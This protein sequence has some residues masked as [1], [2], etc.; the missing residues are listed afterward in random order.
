LYA[1]TA[2]HSFAAPQIMCTATKSIPTRLV[3]I[4]CLIMLT[5]SRQPFFI[6]IACSSSKLISMSC[7][8]STAASASPCQNSSMFHMVRK[9][10]TF[11]SRC[12]GVTRM[13]RR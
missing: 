3:V 6:R 1:V 11:G 12:D 8:A 2:D 7:M 5:A 9:A 13:S 10:V 4:A